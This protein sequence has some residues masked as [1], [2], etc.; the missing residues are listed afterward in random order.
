M[1]EQGLTLAMLRS[2]IRGDLELRVVA[3]DSLKTLKTYSDIWEATEYFNC[4]VLMVE[5]SVKTNIGEGFCGCPMQ[6]TPYVIVY[7]AQE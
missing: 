3:R 7:V 2:I 5:T 4:P 6:V 1:Q